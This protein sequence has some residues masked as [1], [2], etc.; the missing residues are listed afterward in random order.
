[1]CH[2]SLTLHATYGPA[3]GG[4]LAHQTRTGDPEVSVGKGNV[5]QITAVLALAACTAPLEAVGYMPQAEAHT[6][7][8]VAQDWKVLFLTILANLQKYLECN[9]EPVDDVHKAALSLQECY[10]ARGVPADADPAV[11]RALIDDLYSATFADPGS[12][13]PEERTRLLLDLTQMY[14][15]VGGN[16][17]DLGN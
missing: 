3:S 1:M 5:A 15:T 10:Y 13:A 4:P 9:E 2:R 7:A 16:P 11:G 17:L 8:D 14:I 6:S 12:L